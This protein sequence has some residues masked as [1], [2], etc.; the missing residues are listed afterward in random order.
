MKHQIIKFNSLLNI[1]FLKWNRAKME[2]DI[3]T[4][5]AKTEE[6]DQPK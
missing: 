1:D 2:R 3:N 5:E 6:N 4:S